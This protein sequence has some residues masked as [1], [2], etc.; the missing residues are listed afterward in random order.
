MSSRVNPVRSSAE[1]ELGA[2]ADGAAAAASADDAEEFDEDALDDAV[3]AVGVGEAPL[4]VA[5]T[6][7]THM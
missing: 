4:T 1:A 5:M 6:W 2:V 7:S 3:C